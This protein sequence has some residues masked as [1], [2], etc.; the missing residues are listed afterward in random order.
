[1]P[2]GYVVAVGLAAWCTLLAV[3]PLRRPRALGLMSWRF[4]LLVSEQPFLAFYWLVAST[5]LA[6]AQGDLDSPGGWAALGLAGLTT[7]G[8]VVIARRAWRTGPVAERALADAGVTADAGIDARLGRRLPY[9][10][11]LLAPFHVRRG[12]VER[13]ANVSYGDAGERNLLDVYR[14]RSR[15]SGC[16]TLVYL[17]GGGFRGGRKSREARP[18]LYRL[19]SRGWVCISANYRL[20]PEATFPDHLVDAKKVI[21]WVRQHG[22]AYGADPAAVVVAGSSAGGNLAALAALTPNDPRFQPGFERADTTVAAAV[23]L[24]GY[25]GRYYGDPSIP[26]PIPSPP[27]AYANAEAPPFLVAHGD[28]DTF[29]PVESARQFVERLRDVSANP[30]VYVE[31]PGAQHSFDVFH[32]VRFDTLVEG[33]EAFT[34]WVLR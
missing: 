5:A 34:A 9:A 32:S 23:C 11:I 10:R 14:H 19:A 1:V 7:V 13:V 12:D 20:R 22:P 26:E 24:Y 6:A 2:I 33:I 3:A 21:A 31:L 28:Q 4:G 16:P 18:L 15:P 30:V 25:Y 27:G 8:L 29:V 17:H